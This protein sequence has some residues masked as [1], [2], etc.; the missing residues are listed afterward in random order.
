[1]LIRCNSP[2][3]VCAAVAVRGE[4]G[5]VEGL[6]VGAGFNRLSVE[7]VPKNAVLM[8]GEAVRVFEG[9]WPVA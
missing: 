4:A 3:Q 2:R 1:M 9:E 8:R 5:G 6:A 7:Y